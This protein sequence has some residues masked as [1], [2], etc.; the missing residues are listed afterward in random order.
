MIELALCIAIIGFAL[1]A[2]MGVMPTGA[3]TQKDNR[4]ETIID[5]DARYLM[6]AIRNGTVHGPNQL[7]G[8]VERTNA[9]ALL[10]NVV[11]GNAPGWSIEQ[12]ISYLSQ[13]GIKYLEMRSISGPLSDK[14]SSVADLAFRYRLAVDVVPFTTTIRSNYLSVLQTNLHD[15]RLTF[16]W[17]VR[18]DGYL[19]PNPSSSSPKMYRM[20]VRGHY[21]NVAVGPNTYT[22]LKP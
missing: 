21:E 9:P 10:P 1:V 12:I 2:I 15:V 3:R 22:I 14:A 16:E 4:E 8:L 13:P 11:M 19:A 20:L 6:Q 7:V 5:Q 18:P 17:P